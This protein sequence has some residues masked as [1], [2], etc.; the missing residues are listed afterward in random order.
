MPDLSRQ[1]GWDY[2]VV[3]A[4]SAGSVLA[5]RLSENPDCRVLLLEHGAR[6]VSPLIHIPGFVEQALGSAAI[7]SNFL[8]DPDPS[9]NGRQLTWLAGRV[10]GGSSS[11]NGMVYGRGLPVDYAR[12]VEAGNP[13][14]GWDDMLPYFRRA[15]HWTGRPNPARGS[16]GPLWV[17]RFEETNS[18]CRTTMEALIGAGV[19]YVED[20]CTGIS[21]GIGLTQGTQKNGWRHSAASAYL[22]P[23]RRR[24]NLCILTNTRALRLLLK[25]GRCIGLSAERRGET[26][27]YFAARETIVCAGAFGT[28]HLLLLS[29]IGPED[30]LAPHGIKIAHCLPGVGRNLND[31]VNIRLSA[32]VES[33]TYNT[34][35]RGLAALG[36]GVDFFLR[37]KGPASSPANHIQAF[38]KT[39][40]ALESADI[41]IQLMAFGF[42]SKEQMRQNGITT[43]VSPCQPQARGRV[44]LGSPD[45]SAPPRI[46]VAMLDNALDRDRLLRGCHMARD[47]LQKSRAAIYAPQPQTQSDADWLAFFRE[48]AALNWHPTSTCRMGPGA[49]DVVDGNFRVHGLTGIRI[50]D[51]SIMPSVTSANTNAVVIAIAER[52]AESVAKR[53]H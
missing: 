42:G 6:D 40:P 23:A 17:R 43:V 9:L 15:E 12:W 5:A 14:W 34:Q 48:T 13:G 7:G 28:P 31:H 26:R 4:G 44:Y 1:S 53:Q 41:Q 27:D 39:D 16:D 18:A 10:L 19:P 32:F 30:A 35:R 24:K 46:A 22:N 37:G 49:D 52:A 3:G 36:H 25:S 11:I 51:A 33:A 45:P 47:A 50:A 8:G 38:V 2:I 20:Y 21:E 29:G